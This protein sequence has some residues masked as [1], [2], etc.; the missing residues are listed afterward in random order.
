MFIF[1]V[2]CTS[3]VLLERVVCKHRSLEKYTASKVLKVALISINI[4]DDLHDI[5]FS[6]CCIYFNSCQPYVN[7]EE[8][9]QSCLPRIGSNNFKVLASATKPQQR[10]VE[11]KNFISCRTTWPRKWGYWWHEDFYMVSSHLFHSFLYQQWVGNIFNLSQIHSEPYF[12]A[13]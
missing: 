4:L 9:T 13:I 1:D 7:N 6:T 11:S 10:L 5:I 12:Q 3:R 2:T 8:P